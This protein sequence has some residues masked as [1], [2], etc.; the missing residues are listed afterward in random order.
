[1]TQAEMVLNHLQ[2]GGTITPVTAFTEYGVLRLSAII[3]NLRH[4][5][6]N[7]STLYQTSKNRYGHNVTYAVYKLEN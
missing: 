4:S 3:Y 2:E 1:M 7:I 5:G 6:Y